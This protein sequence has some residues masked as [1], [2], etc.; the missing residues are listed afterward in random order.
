M[1]PAT[2]PSLFFEA[3]LLPGLDAN[4]LALA[5]DMLAVLYVSCNPDRLAA[6]VARLPSFFFAHFVFQWLVSIKLHFQILSF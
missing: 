6:D 2:S 4:S 3:S 1:R 5:A